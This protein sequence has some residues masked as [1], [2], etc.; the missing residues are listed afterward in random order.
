MERLIYLLKSISEISTYTKIIFVAFV[1][2]I[3]AFNECENS[4]VQYSPKPYPFNPTPPK[5]I[6]VENIT[7]NLNGNWTGN[8]GLSYVLTQNNSRVTFAEYRVAFIFPFL[9]YSGSGF[10]QNNKI[11]ISGFDFNG[12]QFNTNVDIINEETLSFLGADMYGNT[13]TI[14]LSKNK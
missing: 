4:V 12:L 6:P 10:I 9:S 8:N 1:G 7:I 2:C 13:M 5:P 14:T 11:G 3:V